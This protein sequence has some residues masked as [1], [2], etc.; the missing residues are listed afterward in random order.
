MKPLHIM[1]HGNMKK[2]NKGELMNLVYSEKELK[3]IDAGIPKEYWDGKN[4]EIQVETYFHVM[5][6]N[7]PST[8]GLL[9]DM[10]LIAK[11]RNIDLEK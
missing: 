6:Y 11:S 1:V 2:M 5:N 7:E 10:R 4:K 9:E 8:L 3:N